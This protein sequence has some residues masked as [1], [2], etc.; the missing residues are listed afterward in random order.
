MRI[1]LSNISAVCCLCTKDRNNIKKNIFHFYIS[2]IV[3]N[4]VAIAMLIRFG[5]KLLKLRYY[6]RVRSINQFCE[7]IFTQI[8]TLGNY[9]IICK[10]IMYRNTSI[11]NSAQSHV[12]IDIF[13]KYVLI[14]FLSWR[15]ID[16]RNRVVQ[17]FIM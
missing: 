7:S 5:Y 13:V 15:K 8:S 16:C 14:Y 10:N 2:C 11:C 9:I 6:S 3:P 12:C 17:L 1:T 4:S